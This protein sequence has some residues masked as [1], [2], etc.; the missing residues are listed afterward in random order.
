MII[1][2]RE[3]ALDC[4][5]P[6]GSSGGRKQGTSRNSTMLGECLKAFSQPVSTMVDC[7]GGHTICFDCRKRKTVRNLP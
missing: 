4:F 3:E 6:G 2:A 5:W 1:H 7:L